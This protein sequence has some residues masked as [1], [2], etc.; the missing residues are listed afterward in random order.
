M[1]L[2][3]HEYS[4]ILLVRRIKTTRIN[5]KHQYN[6]FVYFYIKIQSKHSKAR[7]TAAHYTAGVHSP[8]S[9]RRASDHMIRP[10]GETKEN[11]EREETSNVLSLHVHRN[12]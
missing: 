11:R 2:I 8:N 9:T 6:V 1:H 3:R 4:L 5:S 12:N 7:V 10:Y